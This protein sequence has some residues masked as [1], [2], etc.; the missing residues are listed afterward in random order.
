MRLPICG[1]GGLN[2]SV[3]N[4]RGSVDLWSYRRFVNDSFG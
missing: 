2:S 3:E 4:Y 1:R